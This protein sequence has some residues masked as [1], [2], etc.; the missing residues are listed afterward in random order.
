MRAAYCVC[1]GCAIRLESHVTKAQII[2]CP[3]CGTMLEVLGLDPMELDW[4]YLEPAADEEIREW[5]RVEHSDWETDDA[6]PQ[7][8]A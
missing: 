6:E 5:E 4:A 1:C 3:H 8:Y 7:P 2:T